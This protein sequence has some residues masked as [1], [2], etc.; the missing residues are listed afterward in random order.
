MNTALADPLAALA[1]KVAAASLLTAAADTELYRH[2]VYSSGPPPLAVFRPASVE[3]LAAGIG[4]ATRAGI[5]I[6]PRG[7]GMSYTGGYLSPV[8]DFILVDTASLASVIAVDEADMTVTVECGI[9]WEALRRVLQ[10]KGLRVKAWGTLS[11][12]NATVGGGMSQNGVFWGAGEGSVVDSALSFD[13]VLADGTLVSTGS[14]FFRPYGPDLTGLFAADC[15]AFGVKARATLRL[16]REGAGLAYGSF[17]FDDHRAIFAA[18]SA[19]AREGLASESFGFD[20]FLQSQ[21]MK[22][23]S[24]AA[25]AKSLLTMMKAQGSL[26][27]GLKEGAKVALAGRGFLD[28]VPFSLHCI[29]ERRRQSEAEADM[30]EIARLAGQ[31][32]GK[33]VENTIPK[34]LRANPFPPVNSMVGPN[35]ERWVPVHGFLPHSRLVEGWEAVQAL[36]AAHA[37]DMQAL[38]VEAGA[39]LAAVSPQAC[40]IE[41]VFFWPDLLNPLHRHA[42]EPGH[43]AKLKGFPANADST[44][45]VARLRAAVI[46]IFQCLGTVHLQIARAYPLETRHSREGWA[47]LAALKRQIDPKGLMNPGS[48]GL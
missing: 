36:F 27:K 14:D 42:V 19:I 38:G 17:A 39:M 35:G 18:M 6:V 48:L 44:A 9:S 34:I 5:A 25:D 20:P 12:I 3:E 43:L 16:V 11:G 2:D 46:D 23:D 47:I 28:D 37:G 10:P 29:A 22:R 30:A 1:G 33:A 40:L 21:R 4:A 41:P 31:A 15:G 8:P 32:G 13:V 45:L 26:L 7:G 24:L